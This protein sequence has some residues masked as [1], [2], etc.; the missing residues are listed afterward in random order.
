MLKNN[1]DLGGIYYFADE[2]QS[3]GRVFDG[4]TF[5]IRHTL[6]I[7]EGLHSTG[8]FLQYLPCLKWDLGSG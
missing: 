1:L 7:G 8:L 6:V 4:V 5:L 3:K 2:A